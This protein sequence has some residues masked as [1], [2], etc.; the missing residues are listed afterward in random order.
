MKHI[1]ILLIALLL[2]SS[3]SCVKQKIRRNSHE[4]VPTFGPKPSNA[5]ETPLSSADAAIFD[6]KVKSSPN[7]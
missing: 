5:T 4:K 3:I 2:I 6:A 7:S 1:T